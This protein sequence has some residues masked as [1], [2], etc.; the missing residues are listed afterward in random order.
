MAEAAVAAR[1]L[2][3]EAD[4]ASEDDFD[5]EDVP[6]PVR[7]PQELWD[8]LMAIA[9]VKSAELTEKA[10]RKRTVSRNAVIKNFLRQ[11]VA[12]W[13][14]ENGDALEARARAEGGDDATKKP[15]AKRP[16]KK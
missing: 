3:Y 13:E 12:A 9:S 1:R 16:T 7:L 5:F 2:A 15:A 6:S 4:V 8:R 10:G 11:S 14:A